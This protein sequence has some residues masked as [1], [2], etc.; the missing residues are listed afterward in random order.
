M[1]LKIWLSLLFQRIKLPFKHRKT[2]AFLKSEQQ[3]IHSLLPAQVVAKKGTLIIKTDDIGDYLIWQH[4]WQYYQANAASPLYFVGNVVWKPLFEKFNGQTVNTFWIDKKQWDD[5]NYRMHWYETINNLQ[6]ETTIIPS[7]TRNTRI[8]DLL[9][10]ASNATNTIGWN[11]KN[12][13]CQLN[14]INQGI[15]PVITHQLEYFRNTAFVN[16]VF[17]LKISDNIESIVPEMER[18]NTLVVFSV[19]NMRSKCWPVQHY[20]ELISKMAHQFD[21]ICLL[22]GQDSVEANAQI[23]AALKLEKVKNYS[24]QTTLL[25]T[26]EMVSKCRLVICPD[27][28]ALHM[29]VLTNTPV[30]VKSNGVNALRFV[31]YPKNVTAIFPPY[32]RLNPNKDKTMYSRSEIN[33]IKVEHVL[34]AINNHLV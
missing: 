9:A 25:Q 1:M 16:Q 28:A 15:T 5:V 7:F 21:T 13:A 18:Q 12:L 24:Q 32:F 17:N 22:G 3:R 27:T 26:I 11:N 6:V 23:E 30:I 8:E 14:I 29:A 19:A 4:T 34:Q 31:N 10:L 2:R 20:V 33:T